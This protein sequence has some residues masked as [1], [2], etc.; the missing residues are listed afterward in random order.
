MVD[1]LDGSKQETLD[2]SMETIRGTITP[3]RVQVIINQP[4][5]ANK[6]PRQRQKNHG[7]VD[8]L[9]DDA[10]GELE[11]QPTD[12]DTSSRVDMG[13]QIGVGAA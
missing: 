2:E 1:A 10:D 9:M 4:G 13:D 7:I 5:R 3:D 12:S 6:E 8:I 11:Y